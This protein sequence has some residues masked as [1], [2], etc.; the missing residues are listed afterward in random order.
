M[1][2]NTAQYVTRRLKLYQRNTVKLR[3]KGEATFAS[4]LL[5]WLF[6]QTVVILASKDCKGHEL[7]VY[8]P[9]LFGSTI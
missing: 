4:D 1:S 9:G 5:D 3:C 8:P 6:S 7:R 2:L